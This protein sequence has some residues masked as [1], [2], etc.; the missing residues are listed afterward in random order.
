MTLYGE[1]RVWLEQ[2]PPD[3]PIPY[4]HDHLGLR[5]PGVVVRAEHWSS[6]WGNPLEGEVYFRVVLLHQRRGGL[7]PAIQDPRVVVCLPA[8]GLSRRRSRLAGEVSTTRETQAAYL[9]QRDTEADLIRRNLQ[10]RLLGLEEQI[11]AEDSVRY[12]EGQLITGRERQPDPASVFAGL[13]PSAWF[14]RL[15]GWVLAEAYPRLPLEGAALPRPVTGGDAAG[16]FGAIFG[17]PAAPNGIL[18]ELGPG[19][20]LSSSTRP[21]AFDPS[22][23]RVLDLIRSWLSEKTGTVQWSDLHRYLSH[24]VGLTGPLATLYLL[25]YIHWERPER[26]LELLP[27]H[28]LKLVDERPLLGNRITA[29]LIPAIGWDQCLAEWVQTIGPPADPQWNNTLHHLSAL[30]PGMVAH[31]VIDTGGDIRPQE[32]ALMEDMRSLSQKLAE[33]GDLLDILGR[34]QEL[35]GQ[36][37]RAE[38]AGTEVLNMNEVLGRL[39]RISGDG[40]R[41]V[42]HSVRNVYS[43]YRDL[44]SDLSHLRQMADLGRSTED[45][46]WAQEYLEGSVTPEDRFPALSVDRQALRATLSPASLMES[47]GRNWNAL[48]QDISRFKARFSS[49][50]RAHH[51]SVHSRLALYRRDLESARRKVGALDLLNTLPELGAPTGEGLGEAIAELGPVLQACAVPPADLLLDSTP[52]CDSCRLS[53]AQSLPSAALARLLASIDVELGAKNRELSNLLVERIIQ[54]QAD[55]R[56]D[57]FLKIVQASDLSA[58]SNT[59]TV[60]LLAFIRR[61]LG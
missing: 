47:S 39:S 55:E 6:L 42:Y 44:E 1:P 53:L 31:A 27:A 5:Y 37:G 19:L 3:E 49:A 58:L 26:V 8:A 56:L 13:D 2:F 48:V 29:D 45:I 50:Y 11:L 38:E 36:I 22:S 16:L 18:E 59:I 21:G 32:Q 33:A 12:S 23:C 4:I 24:Q 46:L 20:G 25:V 9:T 10:H 43:D 41:S 30:S 60:E 28:P 17:Q 40:F 14:S 35:L 51:E 7:R 61:M 52:W 54:G 34:A 57:D 15:A